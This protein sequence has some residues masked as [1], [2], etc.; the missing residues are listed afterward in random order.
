M[1][2][3]RPTALRAARTLSIMSTGMAGVPEAVLG[4]G[5]ARGEHAGNVLL[6][7]ALHDAVLLA[8]WA[9]GRH[10]PRRLARGLDVGVGAKLSLS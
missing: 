3:G 6:P 10:C 9:E 7:T 8:R 5:V 2:V 4:V 1:H